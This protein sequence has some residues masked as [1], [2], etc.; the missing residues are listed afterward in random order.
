[1]S[2]ESRWSDFQYSDYKSA[3]S[4]KVSDNADTHIV[5]KEGEILSQINKR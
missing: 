1:M 2:F 3:C 4:E 5:F